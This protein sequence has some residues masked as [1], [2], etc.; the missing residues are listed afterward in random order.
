MDVVRAQL[1]EEERETDLDQLDTTQQELST[2]LTI[3]Q[4]SDNPSG[5][6]L[7][8]YRY[9]FDYECNAMGKARPDSAL[10]QEYTLHIAEP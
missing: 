3:N 4:P 5:T 10:S 8:H 6:S 7:V 1:F 9:K 2:G